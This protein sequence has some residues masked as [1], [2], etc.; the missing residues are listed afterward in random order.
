MIKHTSLRFLY[1][2]LP[3]MYSVWGGGGLQ[4]GKQIQLS[5]YVFIF[6]H[7][8]NMKCPMSIR[9][10]CKGDETLDIADIVHEHIHEVSKAAFNHLFHHSG[11][12][13]G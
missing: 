6:L 11:L 5:N 1:G 13:S 7:Q 3:C 9:V 4:K 12:D 2:T 8:V 10:R